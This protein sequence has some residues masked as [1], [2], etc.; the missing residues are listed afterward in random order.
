M[1]PEDAGQAHDFAIKLT[2][3]LY[4]EWVS[5]Q[6]RT[7][8]Q[9]SGERGEEQNPD[10]YLTDIAD[11]IGFDNDTNLDDT[12]F[13]DIH[14]NLFDN[15]DF[16]EYYQNM[17]MAEDNGDLDHQEP[18]MELEPEQSASGQ[19]I[20]IPRERRAWISHGGRRRKNQDE[21]GMEDTRAGG[22]RDNQ[23]DDGME[24]QDCSHG[25]TGSNQIQNR[26]RKRDEGGQDRRRIR[27]GLSMEADYIGI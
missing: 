8:K 16:D 20:T 10:E 12:D 15:P 19:S 27:S 1:V 2:A 24:A 22:Q 26:K 7:V 5:A 21:D 18:E 9:G 11:L 3:H 6:G 14:N 17:Q 4:G 13:D 25:D 23:N